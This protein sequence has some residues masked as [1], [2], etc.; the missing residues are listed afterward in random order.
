[1]KDLLN[2]WKTTSAGFLMIGG[3]IIHLAFS[4]HSGIANEN[5]YTIALGAVIGGVGLMFAGDAGAKPP[6]P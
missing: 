6:T 2:N 3:S 5:T 1:M 4:I